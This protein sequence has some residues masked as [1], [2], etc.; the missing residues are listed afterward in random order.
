MFYSKGYNVGNYMK[1][2]VKEEI[3]LMPFYMPVP[4]QDLTRNTNH[5]TTKL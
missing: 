4:F 1:T 3:N 2:R 5:I